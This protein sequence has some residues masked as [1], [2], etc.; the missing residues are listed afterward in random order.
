LKRQAEMLDFQNQQQKIIETIAE[1]KR[2]ATNEELEQ[3]EYLESQLEP[4]R[5]QLELEE[6]ITEQAKQR[7]KQTEEAVRQAKELGSITANYI[8][9]LT[10][11]DTTYKKTF[12]GSLMQ[13]V[14][15]ARELFEAF[16]S[17]EKS[18][19]DIGAS[20]L[21]GIGGGLKAIAGTLLGTLE[22][23]FVT[24]LKD[25]INFQSE[26]VKATGRIE[27]FA[28][29]TQK[30]QN[31]MGDAA[32][33]LQ[34]ARV[35]LKALNIGFGNFKNI[36]GTTRTELEK[37]T[38]F[39]TAMGVQADIAVDFMD[40]LVKSFGFTGAEASNITKQF[41]GLS[42]EVKFTTEEMLSGFKAAGSSL[43]VFGKRAKDIFGGIIKIADKT[44]A[45]I[46]SLQALAD[47]F[48]TFSD[49]AKMVG[50]LNTALQGNFFNLEQ[51][52][53][54]DPQ[55]QINHIRDVIRAR[56]GDIDALNKH[57][58]RMIA[59]AMGMSNT[60]EA[61]AL[62]RNETEKNTF[63]LEQYGI[64]QKEA[65]EITKNAAGPMKLLQIRFEEMMPKI[66]PI[67]DSLLEL[68][69]TVGEFIRDNWDW[70]KW[71]IGLGTAF[72]ALS[73]FLMP[74][75]AA[76]KTFGGGMAAR[77]GAM[78]LQTKAMTALSFATRGL[79][80]ASEM[81]APAIMA[82]GAALWKAS[83]PIILILGIATAFFALLVYF[84][85]EAGP[86]AVEA[87]FALG[88]AMGGLGLAMA[89]IALASKYLAVS[90]I[91]ALIGLGILA[92]GLAAVGLALKLVSS[93]DLESLATIMENVGNVSNPFGDWSTGL[94]K[95]ANAA[96]DAAEPISKLMN[97]LMFGAL[98]ADAEPIKGVVEVVKA[99]ASI[100]KDNV[101][102]LKAASLFL[103][104]IKV[105]SNNA[106]VE[107]LN[108]LAETVEGMQKAKFAP[109]K[110]EVSLN[111]RVFKNAV[112]KVV[113]DEG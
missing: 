36:S 110:V 63:I 67:I 58:K 85:L 41:Q 69:I 77:A 24:V 10:T 72:S 42:K 104:Q 94:T 113:Q 12:L 101:E 92:V 71:V 95:F 7:N 13:S 60:A 51:I 56:Y 75:T 5:K 83:L 49:G 57:Q 15:N 102:G 91:G 43:G 4:L 74:A 38:T 21:K 28:G 26:M 112:A 107:A 81:S 34:D 97:Q 70:I 89:G 17:T 1:E 108:T 80:T 45:S 106:Q 93:S 47:N 78:A 20:I 99:V 2:N 68:S 105:T 9:Q 31:Q 90:A 86:Q 109:L 73:K 16:K 54:M 65:E 88:V 79:A 40:S 8:S 62:L 76:F 98:F 87:M 66:Q 35:S 22:Q 23:T 52:M 18:A 32:I 37:T 55:E 30:M 61:M 27:D 84:A 44:G 103:H 14:L 53:E 111:G 50:D 59:N 64:S 6:K 39:L 33:S 100:D 82:L 29:Q 11:I 25:S 46:Q 48:N 3:L 19:K 96:E